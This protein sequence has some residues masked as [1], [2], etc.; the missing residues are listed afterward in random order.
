M[1]LPDQVI[2]FGINVSFLTRVVKM[3]LTKVKSL[4]L[5]PEMDF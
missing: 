4:S 3:E 2:S 1:K 5:S